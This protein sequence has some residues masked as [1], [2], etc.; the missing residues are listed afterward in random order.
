M[1]IVVIFDRFWA[2]IWFRALLVSSKQPLNANHLSMYAISAV[3]PA[4]FY[5]DGFDSI[6]ILFFEGFIVLILTEDD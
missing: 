6:S 5:G 3:E 1:N 2:R 4:L